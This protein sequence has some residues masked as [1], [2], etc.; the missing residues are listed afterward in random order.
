MGYA[1][2]D[3]RKWVYHTQTEKKHHI[4]KSY[5]DAWYPILGSWNRRLVVVDGFAGRARYTPRVNGRTNDVEEIEGSPLIMLK[6]LID[7]ER[8]RNGALGRL[9]FV[10]L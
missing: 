2:S 7:H 8:F 1:D 5:L 10:F 9:Q 3:A 4:L 6:S